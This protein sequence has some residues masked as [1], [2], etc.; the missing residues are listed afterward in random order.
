MNLGEGWIGKESASFVSAIRCSHIAA[1]RV[2]REIEHV[3]V[4]A[5]GQHDGVRGML[6]NFSR[7]QVSRH[8]S[9]GL[10]ID[11]HQI[12]HLCLRKHPDCA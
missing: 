3:S 11:N 1:A 4:A 12:E 6:L 2:G 8:D 9:L 7:A 5:A 10:A